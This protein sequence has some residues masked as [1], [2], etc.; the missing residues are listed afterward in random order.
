MKSIPTRIQPLIDRQE[1][2]LDVASAN[3]AVFYSIS[4]CQHG[5]SGISFGNFLIKQV[6][7]ELQKEL[8]QLKRF[9]TLSPIPGFMRWLNAE[10]EKDHSEALTEEQR[11]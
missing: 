9:V 3:T 1:Q 6:V 4:N 7:A 10:R 11:D 8:P 2:L 5:L